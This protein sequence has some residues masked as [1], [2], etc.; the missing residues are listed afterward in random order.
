MAADKQVA[1]HD[2]ALPPG[3]GS[4]REAE[5][6]I[7]GLLDPEKETPETRGS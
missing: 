4:M 2:I 7:L 6:A 5:T 3:E 1:P